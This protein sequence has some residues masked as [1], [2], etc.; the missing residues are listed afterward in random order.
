MTPI[1]LALYFSFFKCYPW[2]FIGK[3]GRCAHIQIE[4][5]ESLTLLSTAPEK[6]RVEGN[7]RA[8]LHESSHSISWIGVRLL[9]HSPPYCSPPPYTYTH[10]VFCQHRWS[11]SPPPTLNIYWAACG[12]ADPISICSAK[13]FLCDFPFKIPRA[14]GC[15]QVCRSRYPSLSR[16][17]ARNQVKAK[18]TQEH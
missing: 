15:G 10:T 1:Y 6:T 2:P 3:V 11:M 4:R 7:W 18:S 8:L 9:P 14:A 16:A 17:Q 12:G 13:R 5:H